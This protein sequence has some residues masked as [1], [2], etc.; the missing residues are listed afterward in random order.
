MKREFL[1]Y[2]LSKMPGGVNTKRMDIVRRTFEKLTPTQRRMFRFEVCS[3]EHT[4]VRYG[5]AKC[6]FGRCAKIGS[7]GR[8]R[9]SK[10]SYQIW[11]VWA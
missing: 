10:R 11:A 4:G 8:N 3:D 7:G 1:E 2:E 6:R 9:G 5:K